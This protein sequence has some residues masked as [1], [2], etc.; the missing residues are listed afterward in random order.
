MTMADMEGEEAFDAKALGHAESV[1]EERVGDGEV[2]YLRKCSRTAAQTILLRGANEYLLDEIDRSLHDSLCVVKRCLEHNTL[3]AG[4][5]AVETNMAVHLLEYA[6][7]FESKQ[8]LAIAEFAE[9]LLVIPKV[10][11]VNAAKDATELIAKLK[12][13]VLF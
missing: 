7:Q 6:N 9:A 4:G 3:V 8:Q 11:A 10:L 5:G 2:L 1:S 12:Y 13:V